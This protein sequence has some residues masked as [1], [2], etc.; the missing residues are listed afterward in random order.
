MSLALTQKILNSHE[1]FVREFLHIDLAQW[2]KAK[3]I[4][5]QMMGPFSLEDTFCGPGELGDLVVPDLCFSFAGWAHDGLVKYLEGAGAEAEKIG[6]DKEFCDDFFLAIMR[7]ICEQCE[8]SDHPLVF[9]DDVLPITY[10]KAVDVFGKYE[11]DP[12]IFNKKTTLL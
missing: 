10:Y 3:C 6:I 4:I 9:C 5:L 12:E 2:N 11:Y 1:P 8:K 7:S